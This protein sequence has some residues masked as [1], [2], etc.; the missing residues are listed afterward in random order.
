LID[1]GADKK[2]TMNVYGSQY[3]TLQLLQTSVRPYDAGIAHAMID[4][5]K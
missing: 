3:S 5:L 2:A 4:I 1:N